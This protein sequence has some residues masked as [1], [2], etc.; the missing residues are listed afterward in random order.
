MGTHRDDVGDAI[1]TLKEALARLEA[2]WSEEDPE[3]AREYLA[4]A[5]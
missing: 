1:K 5:N 2:A 4:S 3:R